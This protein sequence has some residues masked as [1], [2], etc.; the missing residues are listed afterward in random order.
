MQKISTHAAAVEFNNLFTRLI[1]FLTL[2][3][4]VNAPLILGLLLAVATTSPAQNGISQSPPATGDYSIVTR[5]ADSRLWQR[6]EYFTND[7]GVI[8]THTHQYT[9][10][11][12]GLCV[13]SNLASN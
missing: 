4:P 10:L 1:F 12:N 5:A 8:E 11:A 9:E 6:V 7:L 13:A 2:L 3:P